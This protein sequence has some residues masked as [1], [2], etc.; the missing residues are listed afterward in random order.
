MS[1][2]VPNNQ[3]DLDDKLKAIGQ[4]ENREGVNLAEAYDWFKDPEVENSMLDAVYESLTFRQL[5]PTEKIN[6]LGIGSGTAQLET[7]I[8]F[9]L[10]ASHSKE[11]HLTVVDRIPTFK[12]LM[13]PGISYV[14][15]D[16]TNI[17]IKEDSQ[18][19][20]LCRSVNHYQVGEGAQKKF[21]EEVLRTLKPGGIFLNQAISIESNAECDLLMK[22]HALIPKIIDLKNKTEVKKL[23]E[24]VFAEVE[25]T[26]SQTTKELRVDRKAFTARYQP[27]EKDYKNQDE[28]QA[29][30]E[31]FEKVISQIIE[32]IAAVPENKRPHVWTTSDDF[33]FSIPYTIFRCLKAEDVVTKKKIDKI[34]KR[35][36]K[37]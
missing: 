19:L 3:G 4:D 8:T 22:I 27:K 1:E 24:E 2:S 25:E 10:T 15:A 7:K 18:D 34:M 21:Y 9:V 28:Y 20:I 13:M 31:Q 32:V 29:A 23:M 33:G 26:K 36:K 30:N 35:W 12:D 5:Y 37:A 6:I 17:P 16:A 11:S 14:V